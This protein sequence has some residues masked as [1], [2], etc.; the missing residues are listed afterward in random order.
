MKYIPK[1]VSFTRNGKIVLDMDVGHLLSLDFETQQIKYL[2]IIA[3]KYNF[4]DAYIESL[5]LLDKSAK[6][7]V[8]YRGK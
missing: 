6:N 8:T 3:Y 4:V 7:V 1:A 5:V 2:N